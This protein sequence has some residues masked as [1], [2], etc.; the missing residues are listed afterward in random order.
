[1]VQG[2]NLILAINN[3]AIAAAKSCSLKMQQNFIEACSPTSGR[4]KKKI[5][6]DYSWDLSCDCLMATPAYADSIV[7]MVKNGTMVTIQFYDL[8][9]GLYRYGNAYVANATIDGSVGSLSKL[10]ISLT[11]SEELN[12]LNWNDIPFEIMGGDSVTQIESQGWNKWFEYAQAGLR[13][14]Y[15]AIKQ[16]NQYIRID[17]GRTGDELSNSIDDDAYIRE[18]HFMGGHGTIYLVTGTLN[19][20][21]ITRTMDCAIE[22]PLIANYPNT[23]FKVQ[24]SAVWQDEPVHQEDPTNEIVKV[25]NLKFSRVDS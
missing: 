16:N 23:W 14:L 22:I 15:V 3:T 24:C 25:Y 7:D 12:K 4:T 9:L 20:N 13:G 10:S 8:T 6:S 18:A 11:G 1:M 17:D 21:V 5:P 19:G 2:R